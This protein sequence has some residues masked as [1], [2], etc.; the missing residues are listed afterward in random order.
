MPAVPADGRVECRLTM[1]RRRVGRLCWV[2]GLHSRLIRFLRSRRTTGSFWG[3]LHVCCQLRTVTNASDDHEPSCPCPLWACRPSAWRPCPGIKSMARSSN[4]GEGGHAFLSLSALL[5]SSLGLASFSWRYGQPTVR[6]SL[7]STHLLV[8]FSFLL[9]GLLLV[10][11]VLVSLV[12]TLRSATGEMI[13][14]DSIPSCL[15]QPSPSR[16]CPSR[17]CLC[18]RRP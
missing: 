1:L 10:G 17:P 5:L 13:D 4:G 18:R 15:S 9:V 11:L 14:G 2:A 8:L 7:P 12:L 16:P 6:A 3:V